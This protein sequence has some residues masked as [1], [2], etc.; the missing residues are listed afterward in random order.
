MNSENYCTNCGKR[1]DATMVY[2]PDCGKK[3]GTGAEPSTTVNPSAVSTKDKLVAG[4]FAIFLGG[5]GIHYFYLGKISAGVLTIVLTICTC[6]IWKLLMVIQGI[7]MLAMS[8]AEFRMKYVD[9]DKSFP[10]F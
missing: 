3:I 1:L 4:L 5:F 7:L 6:G 9:T 2:C 10:L 8:E